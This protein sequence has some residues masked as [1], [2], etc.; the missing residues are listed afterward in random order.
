[1]DQGCAYHFLFFRSEATASEPGVVPAGAAGGAG[2]FFGFFASLFPC[3]P[4][5]IS[6]PHWGPNVAFCS[7]CGS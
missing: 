6:F 5:V 2:T 3:L 1:M 4:L 7:C